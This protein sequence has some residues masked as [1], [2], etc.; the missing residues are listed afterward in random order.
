MEYG[1][2]ENFGDGVPVQQ[3]PATNQVL[4]TEYEGSCMAFL[5]NY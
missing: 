4:H 5:K 1:H 2:C 3:S